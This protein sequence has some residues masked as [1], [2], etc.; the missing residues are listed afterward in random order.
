MTVWA[1]GSDLQTTARR[2]TTA[3]QSSVT[4]DFRLQVPELMRLKGV[5]GSSGKDKPAAPVRQLSP[6]QKQQ[7]AANGGLGSRWPS[8][9]IPFVLSPRS[10]HAQ[11]LSCGLGRA[12]TQDRWQFSGQRSKFTTL[13]H[14]HRCVT[15]QQEGSRLLQRVEGTAYLFSR[16]TEENSEKSR[17]TPHTALTHSLN[18]ELCQDSEIKLEYQMALTLPPTSHAVS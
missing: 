11:W 1:T 6:R 3:N 4:A 13:A 16:Y 2:T 14:Q 15:A 12:A 7:H 5:A 9:G 8:R 17:T 18:R 10:I